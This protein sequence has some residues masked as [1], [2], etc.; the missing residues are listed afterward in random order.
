M[1]LVAAG[2]DDQTF[3]VH[4]LWEETASRIFGPE[5]V[6]SARARTLALL[7]ER[8]EALRLGSAAIQWDDAGGLLVAALSLVRVSLG[9]LPIDTARRWL[10][11][12]G[13]DMRDRPELRLLAL[14]IRQAEQVARADIDAE[15]DEVIGTFER[16]PDGVGRAE[17]IALAAVAAHGR[18]D[19]GR[20]LV[21]A[22]RA[23]SLPNSDDLPLLRF[24]RGAIDA[25][26]ASLNGDADE[27]LRIIATLP[28]AHVPAQVSELVARLRVTMLMLSGHADEAV[29]AAARL[30]D[31]PDAHV[32]AT[33]AFVRWLSGDPSHLAGVRS[34]STT[35]CRSTTAYRFM[36]AAEVAAV[37][38]ARGD[39]TV[40][41]AAMERVDGYVGRYSDGRHSAITCWAIACDAHPRA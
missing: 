20:L 3:S 13:E 7:A 6:A 2:S 11:A 10:A 4:Q 15:V 30:A 28:F 19:L 40:A 38:S 37:A 33:P 23:G 14:A 41:R 12:A 22:D 35:R 39:R 25:S 34:A 1:P 26:L 8:D 36:R 21:L 17:A 16:R 18:G 32:R 31:S 9:A 5:E 24:L 29:V 27:S